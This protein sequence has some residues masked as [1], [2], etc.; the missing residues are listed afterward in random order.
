MANNIQHGTTRRIRTL[1]QL[2]LEKARLKTDLVRS[3]DKIKSNYKAILSAFALK[4]LISTFSE[5]TGT[6][7]FISQFV[8][9]GV[10][11]LAARKKK[12]KKKQ[13]KTAEEEIK[14]EE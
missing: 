6:P 1:H 12:K 11:W 9:L 4:N 13:G 10:N 3:E 2:Q 14:N 7:S 5:L 8:S